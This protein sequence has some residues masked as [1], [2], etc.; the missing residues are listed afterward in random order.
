MNEDHFL[1]GFT[2]LSEGLAFFGIDFSVTC[3]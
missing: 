1:F 3:S 2:K